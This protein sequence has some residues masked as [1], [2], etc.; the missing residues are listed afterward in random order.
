MEKNTLVLPRTRRSVGIWIYGI[1]FLICSL[2]CLALSIY[3]FLGCILKPDEFNY[4]GSFLLFF[5]I[6][7]IILAIVFML[8]CIFTLLR[9]FRSSLLIILIV[10]TLLT[11]FFTISSGTN[12]ARYYH[13]KLINW[14][15]YLLKSSP[16]WLPFFL[17]FTSAT[18][19][20]IRPKVK[21]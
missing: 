11:V 18:Y 7:L 6:I 17:L 10:L 13:W 4:G 8:L 19:F 20:F 12:D 21:E 2:S 15:D 16:I 9:K 5:S 14:Y 3:F 1:V